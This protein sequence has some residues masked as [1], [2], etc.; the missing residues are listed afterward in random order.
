MKVAALGITLL[1]LW[2]CSSSDSGTGSEE[3]SCR[4]FNG[5][6][7]IDWGTC[8]SRPPVCT[9]S[10]SGCQVT[11]SCETGSVHGTVTG[12]TVKWTEASGATCSVTMSGAQ[13]AGTCSLNG[14]SCS[15]SVTQSG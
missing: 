15:L 4:S 8:P 3:G 5:T 12:D 2:G 13:G 14:Q 9:G 11:L 10:Q 7:Q 6:F 1:L